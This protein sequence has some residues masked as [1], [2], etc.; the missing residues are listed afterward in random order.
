[1]ARIVEFLD[2]EFKTTMINKVKA[3]TEK[4]DIIQEQMDNVNRGIKIP[5]IKKKCYRSKIL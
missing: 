3:L 2:R 1:M 4:V 5:R